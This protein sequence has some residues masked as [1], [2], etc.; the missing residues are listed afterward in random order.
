MM[1]P[2]RTTLLLSVREETAAKFLRDEAR[3]E[4]ANQTKPHLRGRSFQFVCAML[5]SL[6]RLLLAIGR[7]LDRLEVTQPDSQ[8]GNVA[9]SK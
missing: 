4:T 9:P 7:R 6:G 1:Y 2:V 5:H 3:V 8:I